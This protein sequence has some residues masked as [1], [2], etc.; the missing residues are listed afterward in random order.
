[1]RGLATCSSCSVRSARES[2]GVEASPGG[3]STRMEAGM[4][5]RR[6][7]EGMGREEKTDM[8][9]SPS[10]TCS[11]SDQYPPSSRAE[12]R[13]ALHASIGLDDIT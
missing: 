8:P 11:S 4:V 5:Q 3:G 13:R 10:L 2:S 1:M 9:R 6:E 7:E 12:G